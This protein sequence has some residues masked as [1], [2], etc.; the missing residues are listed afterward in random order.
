[1]RYHFDLPPADDK[2]PARM[3]LTTLDT[4]VFQSKT[5]PSGPV[6]INCAFREPLAGLVE[7]WDSACLKG[8]D[9]WVFNPSPFTTHFEGNSSSGNLSNIIEIVAEL[10]EAKRGLIVVGGLHS[11]EETWAVSMLASHMG[12]PV[13]PDVLSGLRI[14]DTFTTGRNEEQLVIHHFDQILLSQA[15]R[16][17]IQTDVILQVNWSHTTDE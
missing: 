17:A 7:P 12:W 6:H 8:L 13:I 15:V 5:S 2:I 11:G 9:R 10:K 16:D 4:A 3:V 14:G 1:M